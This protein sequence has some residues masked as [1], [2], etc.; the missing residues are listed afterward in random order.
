MRLK[1]VYTG[2][3]LEAAYPGNLGAMEMFKF[4]QMASDDEVR[5]MERLLS[6]ESYDDV[7]ELLKRVTGVNLHSM[8]N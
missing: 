3:F 4:Y 5:E 1:N 8:R 6:A 7:W 2:F